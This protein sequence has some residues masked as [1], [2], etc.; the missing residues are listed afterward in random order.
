MPRHSREEDFVADMKDTGQHFSMGPSEGMRPYKKTK[1]YNSADAYGENLGTGGD[2]FG[3]GP[4]GYKRTDA[5]IKDD[6][7]EKLYRDPYIDASD[8]EVSVKNGIVTLEGTIEDRSVKRA[9]EDCINDVI[10]INDIKNLLNVRVM[11][12]NNHF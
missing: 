11:K 12:T 8:I 4:K 5:Q 1:Q 2:Y 7:S 6:V 9:V 10:G 3:K